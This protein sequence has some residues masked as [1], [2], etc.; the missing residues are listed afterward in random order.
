MI[1]PKDSLKGEIMVV[2]YL[3]IVSAAPNPEQITCAVPYK[4]DSKEIFF[5]PCKKRLRSELRK[6]FLSPTKTMCT[7]EETIYLVGVNGS[8][9][10]RIRQIV[11]AGQIK[12]IMT[13]AHAFDHLRAK[14]YQKMRSEKK[15]PLHVEPLKEKN[16][17]FGYRRISTLHEKN[18]S[19]IRDI[20]SHYS[21]KNIWLFFRLGS[22]HG[23]QPW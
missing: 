21:S 18:N 17:L 20:V 22:D 8:N 16:H 1:K 12:R 9:R 10:R 7:P 11:W 3:Y 6:N 5:G 13:F 2:L 15:S 23:N 14:R 4:I 19:W